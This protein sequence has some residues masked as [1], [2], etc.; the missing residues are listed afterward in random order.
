MGGYIAGYMAAMYP[1]YVKALALLDKSASGPEKPNPLP[2]EQIEI[3]DP[4]TKD[5]PM[6]FT[7]LVEAQEFIRKA[8]ES[9]LSYQY[10]MNSLVETVDGYQMMFS[11]QAMAAN[12]AYY[13]NWF[14]LLHKIKCPVLMV[15]A[16]GSGAVSD[17]DFASM[18]ALIPHCTAREIPHADHNVHL[19][20]KERFYACFDEWLKG[21]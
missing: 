2:L 14:H 3:S 6:P 16:T 5:W 13:E 7:S 15:R 8:M 12:I 11:T 20:D 4:V 17:Q 10:F 1:G 21:L 19:G 18:Q 9:D